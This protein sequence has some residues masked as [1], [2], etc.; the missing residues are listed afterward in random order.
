M[1]VFL[2]IKMSVKCYF[3]LYFNCLRNTQILFLEKMLDS[4]RF[5]ITKI[6]NRTYSFFSFY[7]VLFSKDVVPL[8]KATLFKLF[9][10]SIFQESFMVEGFTVAFPAR[11]L[12][13]CPS[14]CSSCPALQFPLNLSNS[15]IP[16]SLSLLPEV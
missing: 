16:F 8:Y 15:F 14:P 1:K 9:C 4:L 3:C 6:N 11:S 13:S 2:K 10:L 7:L 5:Q 12:V